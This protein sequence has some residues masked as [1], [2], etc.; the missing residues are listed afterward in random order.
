MSLSLFCHAAIIDDQLSVI[1][2]FSKIAPINPASAT[3][4]ANVNAELHS[5]SVVCH[6]ELGESVIR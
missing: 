5:T 2:I 4:V 6:A 1:Y 3:N